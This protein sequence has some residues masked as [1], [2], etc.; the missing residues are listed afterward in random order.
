M[1]PQNAMM[2]P[3]FYQRVFSTHLNS[4]QYLT[5]QLLIL[6]LQSYRHVRLSILAN[7]FPQPIKYESRVRNLQ[8]FLKLPQLSAKLL[9]FPII[10]QFLKQ[11]ICQRPGNRKQRRHS[12]RLKLIH[13]NR[14]EGSQ[15]V[16]KIDSV[17]ELIRGSREGLL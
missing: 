16:S 12:K 6:L 8:R 10:K 14:S 2:F 1:A 3:Q 4:R 13:R 11:E 9:W 15:V 17:E 7:V 5:L